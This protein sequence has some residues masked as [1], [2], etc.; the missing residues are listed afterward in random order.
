MQRL[1]INVYLDILEHVRVVAEP[2]FLVAGYG[3][4]FENNLLGFYIGKILQVGVVGHLW[5][6][7]CKNCGTLVVL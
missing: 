7:I 3:H 1:L 6:E 4:V 2:Q 5:I